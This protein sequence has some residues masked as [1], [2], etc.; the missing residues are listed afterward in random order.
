M[1]KPWL[2]SLITVET[3]SERD[4]V[5]QLSPFCDKVVKI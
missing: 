2:G 5:S 3:N 1:P 4:V